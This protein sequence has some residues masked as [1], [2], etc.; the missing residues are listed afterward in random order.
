VLVG[1][2]WAE[3]THRNPNPTENCIHTCNY[4]VAKHVSWLCSLRFPLSLYPISLSKKYKLVLLSL[5]LQLQLQLSKIP[6]LSFL[7]QVQPWTSID[8]LSPSLALSAIHHLLFF[9][10]NSFIKHKNK[11]QINKIRLIHVIRSHGGG[12]DKLI[13]ALSF[14]RIISSPLMINHVAMFSHIRSTSL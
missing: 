11:T 7:F 13:V 2:G 12:D 9:V 6:T 3:K 5:F 4:H 10:C 1:C 14:L 8:I